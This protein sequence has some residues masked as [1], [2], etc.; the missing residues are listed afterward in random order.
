MIFPMAHTSLAIDY[1]NS[2]ILQ[3]ANLI[4]LA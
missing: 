4:Q 2:A 3:Y 1:K